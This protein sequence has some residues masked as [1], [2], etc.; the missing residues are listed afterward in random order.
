MALIHRW[1]LIA[2]ATDAVGGLTL[3][4]NGTVTFSADGASFNGSNQWLS[5]TKARP[6]AFSLSVWVKPTAWNNA[7]FLCAS[8]SGGTTTTIWGVVGVSGNL[9]FYVASEAEAAVSGGWDDSKYPSS[10]FTLSVLTYNGS[11][12]V[13]YKNAEA[14]V[15][16]SKTAG[17][18]SQNLSIGRTGAV[19]G[20][21]FTGVMADARIYD[22]PLS[23]LE[24]DEIFAAG[25]NGDIPV[26]RYGVSAAALL[27]AMPAALNRGFR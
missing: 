27:S 3:T 10:G 8:E 18:G 25:P 12:V 2:D 1:P 21:Y 16:Q 9:N 24:I 17:A 6:S 5:G 23:Q 11:Q 14:I 19:N 26:A 7:S 13:G 22:H 4:N 15:T 20:N